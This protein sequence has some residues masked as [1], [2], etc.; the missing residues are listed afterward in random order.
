MQGDSWN[1]FEL[2]LS[3]DATQ[4]LS[5]EDVALEEVE[6][7]KELEI[8]GG[9]GITQN[10][11]FYME[12]GEESSSSEDQQ[13]PVKP[14]QKIPLNNYITKHMHV[15]N[16]QEENKNKNLLSWLLSSVS[17]LFC[18]CIMFTKNIL[19]KAF[20]LEEESADMA[21]AMKQLRSPQLVEPNCFTPQFKP[22][23]SSLN[24]HETFVTKGFDVKLHKKTL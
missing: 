24:S 5:E 23:N 16:Q 13:E 20:G 3:E 1:Q 9:S 14:P 17:V 15:A 11:Q 8:V 4:F 2:E 12:L 10:L 21:A 18:W 19:D 6:E 22:S 7:A